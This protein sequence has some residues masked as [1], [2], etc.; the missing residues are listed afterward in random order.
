MY[1]LSKDV[2]D[3]LVG[4]EGLAG[5]A[6]AGEDACRVAVVE[7]QFAVHVD[8][9]APWLLLQPSC[10]LLA[11]GGVKHHV[12]YVWRGGGR[13]EGGGG[14][15]R[16]GDLAVGGQHVVYLAHTSSQGVNSLAS[17]SLDQD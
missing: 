16:E 10:Y 2:G 14:G 6:V 12:V 17:I 4:V 3:G 13:G 9:H 1:T 8:G 15:G 11:T 7:L 5:L